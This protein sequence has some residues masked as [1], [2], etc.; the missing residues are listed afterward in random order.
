M[1]KL[2]KWGLIGGAVAIGAGLLFFGKDL[3]SYASSSGKMLKTAMKDAIPVQF[4]IQRARDLLEGLIPELHANLRL[5]AEEEVEVASLEKEIA[6]KRESVVTERG[7][8]QRLRNELETR[9]AS[10]TPGHQREEAVSDLSRRFERFRM[11]E[12]L[13]TSQ[14]KL[15][16]NRKKSLQA[17][18]AKLEKTR[19]ARVELAAQIEGLEGQFRILQA[20]GTA[21][22]LR[23]DETKLAQ[24]QRLLSDLR[25]RLE[26]AQ[27]VLEREGQFS[28]TD[29][30]PPVSAEDLVKEI[31]SHL[32][33]APRALAEAGRRTSL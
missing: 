29:A 13:L 14:E 7:Q 10:A 25:K 8:V 33:P 26:V 15:L 27:K 11:N 20:Q 31:D 12:M 24:T 17:A 32:S 3:F 6:G 9:L 19:I 21:S 16:S 4:E 28:E 22:D 1:F 30:A 2:L 5:V 23:I 18:I